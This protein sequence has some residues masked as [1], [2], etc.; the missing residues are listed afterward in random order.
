MTFWDRLASLT[1]RS[2]RE[3]ESRFARPLLVALGWPDEEIHEDVPVQFKLGRATTRGRKPAADIVLAPD[4][5]AP[6]QSAYVVIETKNPGEGI[7]DAKSQAWSYT[8]ALNAPLFVTTNGAQLEVWR[9]RLGQPHDLVLREDVAGLAS[10]RAQLQAALGRREVLSFVRGASVPA[11]QAA[12]FDAAGYTRRL[13]EQVPMGL[14]ERTLRDGSPEG[15]S[16]TWPAALN[17][18]RRIQLVGRLGRGKT[19][20]LWLAADH[21]LGPQPSR[22]PVFPRLRTDGSQ[23]A[24]DAVFAEL[25]DYLGPQVRSEDFVAWLKQQSVLLCIDDWHRLTADARQRVERELCSPAFDACS[26][27]VAGRPG[28]TAGELPGYRRLHIP[29]LTEQECNDLIE[30]RFRLLGP[31]MRHPSAFWRLVPRALKSLLHE[32]VFLARALELVQL[33]PLGGTTL[34]ET[35]SELLDKLF[36]AAASRVP[37]G[38]AAIDEAMQTCELVADGD[39][40]FDLN[41][42][43][44]ALSSVGATVSPAEFAQGLVEACILL[45]Q[46]PGEYDFGHAVWRTYFRARARRRADPTPVELVS[47]TTSP[48]PDERRLRAQLVT[49]S[50][51]DPY[52]Q[53]LLLA[54]LLD[55]DLVSYLQALTARAPA[56]ISR[57]REPREKWELERVA[58]GRQDLVERYLPGLMPR[59][60]PW[61]WTDTAPLRV[62]V[63]GRVTDHTIDYGYALP[64]HP[65]S[66]TRH[67]RG[68]N[69]ALTGVRRDSGRLLAARDVLKEVEELS[70][71]HKLPWVGWIARER[72]RN[73]AAEM[74]PESWTSTTVAEVAS[75]LQRSGSRDAMLVSDH[76][77]L[78]LSQASER[79]W[80]VGDALTACS[81]LVESGQGDTPMANLVL[82]G[83]DLPL[84]GGPFF[85]FY[86]RS[87]RLKR[88]EA[89]FRV[90]ADTYRAVCQSEYAGV[91]EYFMFGEGPIRAIVHH[92]PPKEPGDSMWADEPTWAYWWEPRENW[93][94]PPVVEEDEPGLRELVEAAGHAYAIS[95]RSTEGAS[96]TQGPGSWV[97]LGD[98]IAEGVSE[99]LVK[100]LRQLEEIIEAAT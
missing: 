39:V 66:A 81:K 21:W 7:D 68:T 32:P 11:T 73:L 72:I 75:R 98:C 49:S 48:V 52:K 51:T 59:L 5:P 28:E 80:R 83:P 8:L 40:P 82:P 24:N 71:P 47:W 95:G 55:R 16:V 60:I 46:R 27:V 23:C 91:S 19:A 74:E 29:L 30:A 100:D 3:V 99:L 33:S 62:E 20:C 34:P 43:R 9:V 22:I 42:L 18:H 15:P 1:F 69:L 31:A 70:K 57:L 26:V 78:S 53:D 88:A 87:R 36:T 12:P 65:E 56:D 89:Y 77:F 4:S 86:S 14:T 90:L 64:D 92:S 41:R 44:A 96:V 79:G 17:Q 25:G 93:G 35:P 45:R 50:T 85:R 37:Q 67:R 2:E 58:R 94:D 84:T 13:E 63:D 10:A 54:K 97:V 76:S 6:P 38:L 61:V